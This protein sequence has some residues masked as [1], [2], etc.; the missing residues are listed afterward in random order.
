MGIN[1]IHNKTVMQVLKQTSQYTLT[2][3]LNESNKKYCNTL[4]K[5]HLWQIITLM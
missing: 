3:E 1:E 4:H 2:M 5:N